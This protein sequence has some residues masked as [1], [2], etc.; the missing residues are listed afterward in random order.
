MIIFWLVCAIFVAIGLAF[1]LPPLLQRADND[2]TARDESAKGANVAVYRDQLAELEADLTNGLI[3]PEQY[4]QDR[5]ELEE[6]LLEDVATPAVAARTKPAGGRNLAYVLA[7]SLP[8][9]AVIFYLRLGNSSA[10]S[11]VPAPAGRPAAMAPAE[12]ADTNFSPER[13]E[14]N[15]TAL[16]KRLEQNPGD[17]EGWIML[18][19]SYSSLEKYSEASTA[20]KKATELKANDADLLADYAFAAAMANGRKLAGE[21]TEIIDRALKID[22]ENPKLLELAGSAA[23]EAQ[24]YPRAVSYWEKLMRRTPSDSEIGQ[25]LAQRITEAKTRMGNAVPKR[26]DR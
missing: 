13:I 7:V 23:F 24:D 1:V 22:P 11:A 15:V 26:G 8:I 3:S 14:A 5:Q 9:V 25:A 16:A 19:R 6:R 17:V 21:P 10:L 18:G 4:E 2:D 20:Y 12:I